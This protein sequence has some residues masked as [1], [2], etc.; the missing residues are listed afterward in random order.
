MNDKFNKEHFEKFINKYFGKT[1]P[2]NLPVPS[3]LREQLKTHGFA[4]NRKKRAP[5]FNF[6]NSQMITNP[7]FITSD[8]IFFFLTKLMDSCLTTIEPIRRASSP[9]STKSL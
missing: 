4:I 6:Y 5:I 8:Y 9:I 1:Q 3:S 7:M 2:P